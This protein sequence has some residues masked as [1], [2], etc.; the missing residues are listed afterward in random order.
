MY[1]YSHLS[2]ALMFAHK[3]NYN[4]TFCL[5]LITI[6]IYILLRVRVNPWKTRRNKEATGTEHVK[7]IP[8]NDFR[9]STEHVLYI[10]LPVKNMF[11]T[12]LTRPVF[13]GTKLVFFPHFCNTNTVVIITFLISI[14]ETKKSPLET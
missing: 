11:F 9:G 12:E 2:I 14:L 3:I 8:C 1:K 10:P 6:Y 4:S 13:H 5:K 7:G